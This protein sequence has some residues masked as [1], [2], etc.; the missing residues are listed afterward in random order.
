MKGRSRRML[1][2][3]RRKFPGL[4]GTFKMSRVILLSKVLPEELTDDLDD[5]DM[6]RR[7][8]KAIFKVSGYV[9]RDEYTR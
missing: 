3:F 7:L 2:E 9:I 4:D 1:E 8:E 5:P 6:E